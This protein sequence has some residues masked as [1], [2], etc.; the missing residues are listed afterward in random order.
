LTCVYCTHRY[1][2][3]WQKDIEHN[4]SY[5]EHDPRYSLTGKDRIKYKISIEDYAK[6]NLRQLLDDVIDHPDFSKVEKF[7]IGGGE[8]LL[9]ANFP[10][11]LRRIIDK[12]PT[13]EILISTGLGLS[14][15]AFNNFIKNTQDLPQITLSLSNETTGKYSE[16]IRYGISWNKWSERIQR[17]LKCSNYKVMVTCVV[18]I[19]TIF[20]LINFL[21]FCN[22][23]GLP[24]ERI[25]CNILYTPDFLSV[26][27]YSP[28]LTDVYLTEL[29]NSELTPDDLKQSLISLVSSQQFKVDMHQKMLKFISEFASRRNLDITIFPEKL[30]L[31][32]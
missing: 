12:N 6:S 8:P 14:D 10:S 15:T 29:I 9:V 16:F 21:K 23:I 22:N 24:K 2:S 26:Q 17:L 30:F 28:E 32:I 18:S 27:Y 11:I 25:R 5:F 19:L 4:G 13:I 31:T 1:S 20:D 3:A 7:S